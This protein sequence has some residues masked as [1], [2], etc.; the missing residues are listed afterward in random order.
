MLRTPKVPANVANDKDKKGGK[1]QKKKG[2]KDDLAAY[3][4]SLPASPSGIDNIIFFLDDFLH[5]LPFEELIPSQLVPTVTKD[6]SIFWSTKKLQQINYQPEL[7]NSNGFGSDKGKYFSY[8]FKSDQHN[9]Q[10]I[11]GPNGVENMKMEGIEAKKKVPS[12]GDYT[13]VFG[14]PG[15][16]TVYGCVDFLN[17]LKF[18]SFFQFISTN[19]VRLLI[20]TDNIN[21]PKSTLLKHKEI[22]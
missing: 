8:S 21:F 22:N 18:S 2:G 14:K 12:F 5:V 7:N 6:S 1:D 11:I 17:H 16:F 4:S 20:L 19:K 13:D 10:E 3:E 9:L 15:F